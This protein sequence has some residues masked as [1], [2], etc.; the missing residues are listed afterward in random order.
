MI[1]RSE[2]IFFP[3]KS[4]TGKKLLYLKTVWWSFMKIVVS[5]K[6]TLGEVNEPK[7]SSTLR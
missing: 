6:N 4:I 3:R 7:I 2:V 5:A 1:Q